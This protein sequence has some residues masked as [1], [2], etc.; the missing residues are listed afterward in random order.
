LWKMLS[1]S[2]RPVRTWTGSCGEGWH[3]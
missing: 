2:S 3:L 1:L